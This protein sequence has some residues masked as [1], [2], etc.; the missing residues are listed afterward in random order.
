MLTAALVKIVN[1]HK[2]LT[3]QNPAPFHDKNS[4]QLGVEENFFSQIKGT[5]RKPKAKITFMIL[6]SPLRS[7]KNQ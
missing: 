7:G 4:Q 5:Y 3:G 2:K 1:K 6:L